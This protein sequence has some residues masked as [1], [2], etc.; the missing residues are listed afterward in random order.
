VDIDT[1]QLLGY[2]IIFF[3]YEP[4]YLRTP[5]AIFDVKFSG[6]KVAVALPNKW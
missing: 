5:T 2:L 4:G 1:Q 6:S 3:F